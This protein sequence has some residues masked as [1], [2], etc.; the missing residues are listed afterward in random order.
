MILASISSF[1]EPDEAKEPA[2]E[3]NDRCESIQTSTA[4]KTLSETATGS[5]I[6][7]AERFRRMTLENAS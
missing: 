6:R 5:L 2:G 1:A 7:L 4:G 3:L